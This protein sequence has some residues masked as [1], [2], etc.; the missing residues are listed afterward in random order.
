MAPYKPRTVGSVVDV[1]DAEQ[2]AIVKSSIGELNTRDDEKL[3]SVTAGE[4][5]TQT[6]PVTLDLDLVARDDFDGGNSKGSTRTVPAGQGA[7]PPDHFNNAGMLALFAI[8][9]AAFVITAIW[10]FFWAKDG[11]FV[12]TEHDW[13]DY[14]STVLRRKDADGRTLTNATP[15]TNL[16]GGSIVRGEGYYYDEDDESRWPGQTDT[17]LS[18]QSRMKGRLL[19][20][21]DRIFRRRNNDDDSDVRAYRNEKP[22][23]VGGINTESE[24][25]YSNTGYDSTLD[26]RGGRTEQ[27]LSQVE[28]NPTDSELTG[29]T[30]DHH[31]RQPHRNATGYSSRRRYDE[32]SESSGGYTEPLDFSSAGGSSEYDYSRVRMN[33]DL[34]SD[35]RDY[36]HPI[37]GLSKGYRRGRRGARSRRRDSLSESENDTEV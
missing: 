35:G 28:T 26:P 33:S 15:S 32:P 7:V 37:P 30:D 5:K 21:K 10:F 16:G 6:V 3:Q 2:L 12:W 19:A 18:R 34:E 27:T 36:H 25:T 31:G 8:L 11:G 20:A 1:E 23:R 9:G 29:Y 4:G 24:A 22:A 17:E 14:K 13:E